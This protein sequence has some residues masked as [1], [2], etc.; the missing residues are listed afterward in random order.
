MPS[1]AKKSVPPFISAATLLRDDTT[2]HY[3]IAG[4]QGP[5]LMLIHGWSCNQDFWA[6][7]REAFATHFRVVTLD[8]AGH[9][10]S[11]APLAA[12][13][14]SIEN[15][16]AD[17]EAVIDALGAERAVLVG[18]SMGGAVAVETAIR[19][20]ARC[21][22]VLGVDTFNEAAFY[23]ARPAEEIAQRRRIFEQDFAG[24]MRAMVRNITAE[25]AAP[26]IVAALGDGMAATDPDVGLAVLEHLLAWD[27]EA[28]WPALSVPV[29]TINSAMLARRNEL[30][31]LDG[32]D[33]R[34][35][36]GVGH[37]P[38]M[39]DPAAF[40]ALALEILLRQCA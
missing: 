37:F 35:M 10:L 3:R 27:I 36:E 34:L 38:M 19:L 13:D 4:T 5:V 40:N 30:L 9:G 23:G 2:L 26:D 33:V 20:G 14:W 39:E 1:Q 28:R 6:P 18:H 31:E 25:T 17:V 22:F 29:A 7:Q 32:L 12:R 15:F 24:T 8:L 11:R 16:A 21:R